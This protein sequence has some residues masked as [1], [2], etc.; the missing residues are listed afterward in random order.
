MHL[1]IHDGYW[2]AL[3][4][5]KYI[6]L[7]IVEWFEMCLG[8]IPLPMVGQIVIS[9]FLFSNV[10]ICAKILLYKNIFGPK[11]FLMSFFTEI[12]IK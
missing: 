12:R 2:E 3:V 11:M 7:T 10:Y 9:F 1:V 8:V 5:C 6:Y 4:T